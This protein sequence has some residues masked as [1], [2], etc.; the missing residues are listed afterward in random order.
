RYST[1]SF[2]TS[3]F[4]GFLQPVYLSQHFVSLAH[5]LERVF[6]TSVFPLIDLTLIQGRLPP[7]LDQGA[8]FQAG[9]AGADAGTK[10]PRQSGYGIAVAAENGLQTAQLI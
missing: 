8:I 2:G 4:I 7:V 6:I 5:H 10:L 3:K 1:S 9:I